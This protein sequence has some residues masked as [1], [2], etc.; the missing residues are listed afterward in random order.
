MQVDEC[1]RKEYFNKW[2]K[3]IEIDSYL[4]VVV[5]QFIA[6]IL[7]SYATLTKIKLK[8]EITVG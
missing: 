1:E 7:I 2:N 5:L 3:N 6:W 4:D 8:E